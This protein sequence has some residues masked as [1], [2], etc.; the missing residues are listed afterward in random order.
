MRLSW[1]DGLRYQLGKMSREEARFIYDIGYRVVGIGDTLNATDDDITYAR[2]VIHEAGLVIG[3]FWIGHAAFR[4][5]PR[6]HQEHR[7]AVKTALGIAGKLG[8]SHLGYS[9][10]SMSPGGSYYPHPENHTQKALDILVRHTS[11]LV[12]Y[13]ED[14]N[15]VLCPETTQWTIVNCIERMKEFV[16][17]VDS[18]Y[19]RICFDPVNHMTSQRIYE[20][21]VF[22]STAF[23]FL[24]DCIGSIHCKDV[25]IW[26]Q[27]VISHIDEARMGTGLLDHEALIRASSRLEPWKT[28]S[29]EHISDRNL[30]KPAYDHI[31]GIAGRI[32]H[33]WDDPNLTRDKWLSGKGR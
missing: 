6:E 23:S 11:E 30:W 28:F 4:P 9:V 13:A 8:C 32:G 3:P 7:E 27:I 33:T 2:D 15:V 26:N 31:Q 5:D 16:E 20:S 19:L 14:A 12:P 29:L 10:G 17:R 22:I 1:D 21:G 25:N 24:G 18:P